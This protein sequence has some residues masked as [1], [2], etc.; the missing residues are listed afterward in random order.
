MVGIYHLVILD[1]DSTFKGV[2]FVICKALHI[3]FDIFA[4][5]NHNGTLVENNRVFINTSIT[6][7]AEDR[8]TNGDFVAAIIIAG[9]VHGVVFHLMGLIYFIVFLPLGKTLFPP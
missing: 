4:K 2:F 1:D 9:G 6:I 5:I 3:K 8:G 7:V